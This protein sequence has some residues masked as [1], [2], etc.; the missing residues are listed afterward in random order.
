MF[1]RKRPYDISFINSHSDEIMVM[2]YDFHKSG[3]EPGPN[4]PLDKGASYGYDFKTM[5]HDFLQY[6]PSQKLT[7]IFGMY[8]Y[9]WI[10]DDNGLPIKPARAL[11]YNQIYANYL[12][13]CN[14]KDC[15]ITPDPESAETKITFEDESG[16]NDIIWFEDQGSVKRKE[17]YLEQKG[18]GSV[19]Y[20]AEG[21]F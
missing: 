17:E 11:T 5:I 2:A 8:G 15:K 6:V 18:I 20:W 3:G 19:A 7:V 21:Y 1:Y 4:F 12:S 10:V 13:R 9:D 14:E 16:D